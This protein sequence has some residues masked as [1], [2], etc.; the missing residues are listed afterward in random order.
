[1]G[2]LLQQY[3]TDPLFKRLYHIGFIG[4]AMISVGYMTRFQLGSSQGWLG[5]FL[6]TF[7]NLFGSFGTPFLLLV[8][9]TTWR[10]D[11]S[12][13]RST[14]LFLQASLLSLVI[15]VLIE[16]GH[17]L[18]SLSFWDNNDMAASLLGGLLAWLVWAGAKRAEPAVNK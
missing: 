16:M 15:F 9:Y 6:D 1:M 11:L 13:L 7:P 5:L 14:R 3:L 8:L 10:K 4:I 12:L 17:I 2:M 18:L